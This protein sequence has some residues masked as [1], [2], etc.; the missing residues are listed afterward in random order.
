ME[1]EGG[2]RKEEGGQSRARQRTRK[3]K[4]KSKRKRKRKRK[5]GRGSKASQPKLRWIKMVA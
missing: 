3:R 5:S 2:R 4:G 1:E